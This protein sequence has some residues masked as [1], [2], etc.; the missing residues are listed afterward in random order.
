MRECGAP[1]SWLGRAIAPA[2]G[3]L[4]SPAT[5][6][7]AS[8]ACTSRSTQNDREHWDASQLVTPLLTPIAAAHLLAVRPSGS[9]RRFAPARCRGSAWGATPVHT[10]DARG[11]APGKGG[12]AACSGW[13][14]APVLGAAHSGRAMRPAA[15]GASSLAWGGS[16]M[17]WTRSSGRPSIAA[18]RWRSL[19]TVASPARSS[20]RSGSSRRVGGGCPPSESMTSWTR[21]GTPSRRLRPAGARS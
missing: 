14:A 4:T 13:R 18:A 12:V 8:P 19:A 1:S 10:A 11:M 3:Y 17:R 9:T 15:E 5:T 2:G 7:A 20:T 21:R 6:N 16:S